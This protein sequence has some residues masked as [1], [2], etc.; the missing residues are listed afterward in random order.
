MEYIVGAIPCLTN[1][2]QYWYV[3]GISCFS[4]KHELSRGESKDWFAWGQDDVTFNNNY[5]L[6]PNNAVL[7][8]VLS[9]Y[10][11]GC[12]SLYLFLLAIALFVPFT[13]S[14][15]S[16]GIFKHSLRF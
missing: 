6:T 16:L 8:Y 15:C 1:Q 2:K 10:V 12:F 4:A 13:V 9:R 14:D 11:D 3:I 7:F 5:S